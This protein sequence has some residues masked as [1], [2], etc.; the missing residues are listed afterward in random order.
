MDGGKDTGGTAAVAATRAVPAADAIGLLTRNG[1]LS[2]AG[3]RASSPRPSSTGGS[4]PPVAPTVA[5]L[6]DGAQLLLKLMGAAANTG[7]WAAATA[8]GTSSAIIAA[9]HTASP[10]LPAAPGQTDAWTGTSSGAS[11]TTS[12]TAAAMLNPGLANSTGISG[13]TAIA[14]ALQAGLEHSGLFYESH[15][16]DWI[17]GQ[18]SLNAI[19][20]EPQ[21]A[22]PDN[23]TAL[24]AIVNAQLDLLDRGQ[25]RWQG[26]LWP[27]QLAE[28]WLQ[29][30][31]QAAE[32]PYQAQQHPTESGAQDDARP[33][34]RWQARL[35]TTLPVLGTI[36]TQF[37]LQ[38]DRIE[39][40]LS[41]AEPGTATALQSASPQLAGMLHH[42]GL[43]LQGFASHVSD[44]P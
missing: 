24:P 8:A 42:S 28:L 36:S 4:T 26:E 3:E 37:T 22:L 38:G 18:R 40:K 9:L 32:D 6:S 2:A 10:L 17:A 19:R 39:L 11:S 23:A 20:A 12:T 33:G 25:L 29:R 35:V 31:A 7:A 1:G 43:M 34:R 16:A 5:D 44:D 30:D 15:L 13:T 14:Q 21:A 41:S 27:G